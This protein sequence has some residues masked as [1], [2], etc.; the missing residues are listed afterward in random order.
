MSS[1]NVLSRKIVTRSVVL[2]VIACVLFA[3]ATAFF[4]SSDRREDKEKRWKRFNPDARPRTFRRMME[5][6]TAR[7]VGLQ[8][9]GECPECPPP[10]CP[11]KECPTYPEPEPCPECPPVVTCGTGTTL[12]EGICLPSYPQISCGAGTVLKN[13]QCV[14]SSGSP[15]KSPPTGNLTDAAVQWET[16]PDR[17]TFTWT[18]TNLA[19]GFEYWVY[20]HVGF[21]ENGGP[22][23]STPQDEASD[24]SSMHD[25]AVSHFR[26]AGN[27]TGSWN[28]YGGKP[29]NPTGKLALLAYDASSGNAW[30]VDLSDSIDTSAWA[31]VPTG[32]LS[33]AAVQWETGPDRVTFTW[34]ATNLASG[35]E[36][37]VYPHVGFTENGGPFGSTP[38]DEASDLSSM[39]DM[40]V[41]HFRPAGNSTGSW[42]WYGGKPTNPTG[43]LALLAYDAS[44]GASWVVDLSEEINTSAWAPIPTG[45]LADAAIQ[46]ETGPDRVTFTWTATNLASGY[47]YWVYP[48]VG[49]TENGGPFGSTPADEANDLSSMHDMA[50]SHFRSA[51]NS[52][53][54]WNW[55]GGKPTNP[56]GKLALLAYDASSGA[57]WVVDL[58]DAID[59]SAW[60]PMPT[61]NLSD[62][63]IQWDTGPDRVTFTWT[64][65][66]LASGFEYWVYPHVGFTENGGPFGSTP[67]D[68]ANDLSSMHDMA[69]SH[70]RPAGNGTGSWNWYG[71]KPTNPSGKL[72][73][74]AYD[75]SSGNS[76]VVDLSDA[77]NT[78]AW[79]PMPTGELS[80]AAIQWDTG[81]DR[82]TFTWTATGLASGFE[83]W[84]YPHVGFTE[85][86]GPF[87]ST[88]ADEANDL[89]SMHDMAVS[90]FRSAG[91]STG[92]WN[93]YGGK[94]TNPS[95]QLALLAYDASSSSAWMVDISEEINI[96]AW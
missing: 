86:G 46:W 15:A 87:G 43:K 80:N 92:S 19:S 30:V 79:A 25:M 47:E 10:E 71:G 34:T 41:S 95:G 7:A 16:G 37:W 44:S 85:N 38:Q 74:L 50:V 63:A 20:P 73:L 48:H 57:S 65:T 31:P 14:C 40:A 51:G 96:D 36:Y 69:V 21:T 55:Y 93:W 32:N 49:F 17:V 67:A 88:P 58:S 28:W 72:A 11:E 39:H 83:Y 81:P 66:G 18:A 53:G 82:V 59:T 9:K 60:A 8:K 84:V 94:P 24:L 5:P 45:E 23:G 42:N 75:A 70:F 77:I 90:H 54:S 76:W 2:L 22:F 89:S 26:P 29:T 3:D 1:K 78:S 61:G 6:E 13:G 33:D 62:A 27:S 4:G 56:S 64:A 12:A 68:E 35:Y 52:T 91:N